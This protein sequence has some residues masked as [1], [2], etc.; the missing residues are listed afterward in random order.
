M[1]RFWTAVI[2]GLA[3]AAGPVMAQETRGNIS[4]TVQDAQG[5]V[6]G[7][8]VKITNTDTNTSQVLVT[9]NT[10]YFEAVAL[11]GRARPKQLDSSTDDR[12][13]RENRVGTRGSDGLDSVLPAR[14]VRVGLRN[15]R[16]RGRRLLDQTF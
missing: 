5:V 9:N 12:T 2:L 11:A 13:T 7:A 14:R 8:T 3:M 16:C 10:G 6:P 4:G 15:H 1:V